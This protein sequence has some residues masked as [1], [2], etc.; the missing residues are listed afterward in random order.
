VGA[1]ADAATIRYPAAGDVRLIQPRP[2]GILGRFGELWHYRGL[3]RFFCWDYIRKFYANT[4]LGWLWIPLR[5]ALS[6]GVRSLVFGGILAIPTGDVPYIIFFAVGLAAWELFATTW[7]FATRSLEL[8]RRYLKRI[9]IPRLTVLTAAIAP[10]VMWALLYLA[11]LVIALVAYAIA[12]NTFYLELGPESL[13][14]LA[15]ALLMAAMALALGLWTSVY[16]AQARDPRFIVRTVLSFWFYLTPVIY[17][18]SLVP[19]DLQGVASANPL[20]APMEMIH[21]GLLGD[22]DIKTSGVIVCIATIVVI[23]GL[24]LRFFDKSESLSLDEL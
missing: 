20:T 7:Y 2:I 1:P 23:G 16:G 10:G 11:V 15:G 8:N 17:P 5:P 21:Q 3:F 12:D 22:G 9:Y 24:G 6:I 18:L 14:A 19:S 4:W 13:L